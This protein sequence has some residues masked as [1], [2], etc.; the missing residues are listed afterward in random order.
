[1]SVNISGL[2]DVVRDRFTEFMRDRTRY[3]P[4]DDQTRLSWANAATNLPEVPEIYH[5]FF[6]A[7]PAGEKDP[8]PY[9]VISPTYKGFIQPENEKLIC[10]IG[11]SLHI[12]EQ[13]N[14]GLISRQYPRSEIFL[15]ET[16]TI[17]LHSW[18]TVRGTDTAGDTAA[19]TIKFNSITEHLYAPFVEW[20]RAVPKPAGDTAE[21]TETSPF[22]ALADENFKFMNFGL[23]TIYPGEPVLQFVLQPEIRETVFAFLGYALTRR[24]A[25]AHLAILTERDLILIRDDPT[26]RIKTKAP[27]GGIWNYIPLSKIKS[28]TLVPGEEG[29]VDFTVHLPKDQQVS[30]PYE[31]TKRAEVEKM[32]VRVTE[33]CRG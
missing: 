7:L 4:A 17:L 28:V 29:L 22:A 14:G 16:G 27:Y 11:D 2:V 5:G 33:K 12:L 19:T 9:S 31:E 32:R 1:M 26:Q 20:F 30:V 10:R 8:F 3:L 21:A 24:I 6:D 18:F 25:T 15:I 13:R 23:K